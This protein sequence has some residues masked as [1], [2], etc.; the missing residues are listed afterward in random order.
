MWIGL[1]ISFVLGTCVGSFLN[2]CIHRLPIGKSIVSP[3]SH[4][5]ACSTPI[6]WYYNLPML[7]YLVL[8][9][10]CA[11]CSAPISARYPLVE[12][13]TGVF[14]GVY[15]LHYGWGLTTLVYFCFTAALIVVTFVDLNFRII[16]D[17]ISLPGIAAGLGVSFFRND[18]SPMDSLWGI[19]LGG[20]VLLAVF[21]GYY[22]ITRREGMGLGDVKLLA[23]IGGFLG[24][25]AVL[26]VLFSSSLLGALSGLAVM[27]SRKGNLKLAIPFG[28]FLAIG[29]ILYI[30]TGPSLMGWYFNLIRV[31]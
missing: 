20:G 1:F 6:P 13:M 12:F 18:L 27:A 5:P 30:F 28:P 22:L 29:A 23:M 31:Y 10:R 2:V 11:S 15:Y 25:K 7:S 4:C 8:K 3:S 24:W 21:F 14:A 9:G 26:F 17:V 19:L 16:P